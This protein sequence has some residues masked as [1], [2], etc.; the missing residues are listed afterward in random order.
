M[1]W[2]ITISVGNS[3]ITIE[4]LY[5]ESSLRAGLLY[6]I[7]ARMLSDISQATPYYM[8]DYCASYLG[9]EPINIYLE[10]NPFTYEYVV[11]IIDSSPAANNKMPLIFQ[12]A[13]KN[14]EMGGECIG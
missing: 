1:G 5:S 11:R 6:T 13:V 12:F 10:S 7:A 9:N 3:N 14:I 8:R 2:P 4:R